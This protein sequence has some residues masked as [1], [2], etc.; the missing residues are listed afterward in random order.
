MDDT[1]TRRRLLIGAAIEKACEMLPNGYIIT[2][3]LERNSGTLTLLTPSSFQEDG[4][5][6]DNFGDGDFGDHINSA[7]AYAVAHAGKNGCL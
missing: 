4:D 7:V 3:E 6:I 1:I 2:I 5:I